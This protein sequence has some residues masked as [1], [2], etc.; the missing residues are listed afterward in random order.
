LLKFRKKQKKTKN[1]PDYGTSKRQ[2]SGSP[3]KLDDR[4]R[5]FIDLSMFLDDE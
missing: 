2:R 1:I 5:Q 3:K 4:E